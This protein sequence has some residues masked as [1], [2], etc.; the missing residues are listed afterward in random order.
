[1]P[2]LVTGATGTVGRA[3]VRQL[4]AAGHHVR[5]LTRD[6]ASAAARALPSS[7]EVVAGDF[8]DPAS[9]VPALRGVTRMH[10]VAMGG[11]L[12]PAGADVVALAE[13]SGV[14][15]L[16]HLG[17]DDAS[18]D[19]DPLETSHRSLR[20]VIE[21]SSLE[22]THLFPGEFAANTLDWAASIRASHTV[23]APFPDWNSALVHEADIAAVA[24]AALLDDGHAG[25]VY[26]PT[27]PSA[28]RR[29]DAVRAIGA[30]IGREITFVP[31][32][33]DEARAEWAGVHPPIVIDWFLE[34]GR[35][36]DTNAWVSPD[37]PAVTGN[38]GRPFTGWAHD[39]AADFH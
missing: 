20:R 19:D 2:I 38:P 17:H 24:A 12:G 29:T 27:G 1:M 28:V 10:L 7:V 32:S 22:W 26:M 8:D 5:A 14:R 30:A 6:P 36:P 4:V 31:L 39:H 9:L 37:V 23:R 3:L 18:R 15:R 35:N 13:E 16:V 34:M 21:G 25:R 33:P 11:V